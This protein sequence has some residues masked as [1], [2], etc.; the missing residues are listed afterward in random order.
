M[1]I[2]ILV[3][4]INKTGGTERA[5]ATL[6]NMLCLKGYFITI[7]SLT[8]GVDDVS[9]YELNSKINVVFLKINSIPIKTYEKVSWCLKTINTLK[10]YLK[11]NKTDVVLSTSH[12]VSSL[13]PFVKV[14][15]NIKLVACEH[16]VYNSI[17]IFSKIIMGLTYNFLDGIVVL[18]ETAKKSFSRYHNVV[19]IPNALPFEQE[20]KSSL[21]EKNIL[22]VGRL[23]DVKGLER[24]VPIAQSIK[25]QFP[26]WRISLVGDGEIRKELEQLYENNGLLDFIKFRG[27]VQN[28]K[29]EYLKASIYAMTS[30]F[31]AFPMV[32]LEAQTSGLPLIAFDCPEG[33]SEIIH[34]D[35]D[36][37]L[38]ENDNCVLFT[39]KIKQ[40]I[41]DYELRVRFG[42]KGVDNSKKYSKDKVLLDWVSLFENIS[43]RTSNN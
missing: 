7:V 35:V 40:L 39:E 36:G 21:L 23:S 28:V 24:L 25:Y 6:A 27:V 31:E 22:I 4:D 12:N 15:R 11:R 33:P 29:E 10:I 5:T 2:A 13:L 14:G 34:N 38:I 41:I 3:L 9:Y 43:L 19:V 18:S 1:R 8:K 30:H 26:D 20:K 37:F 17:P 32:L 16:I 42:N